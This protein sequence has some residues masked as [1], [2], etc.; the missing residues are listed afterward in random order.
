MLSITPS[1][2]SNRHVH[3]TDRME[4]AKLRPTRNPERIAGSGSKFLVQFTRSLEQGSVMGYVLATGPRFFLLALVDENIRF[5]GFQCLRL[6]DVKN[7]QV[8][9]RHAT[10]VEAALKLRGQKRPPTPR[11]SVQSIQELLETAGRLFPIVTIH[12]EKVARDVCHIGRVL[13][14]SESEVSLL[15]IGPDACWDDEVLSYRTKQIT[16]VDFGG[17]YEQA[18][19][20]VAGFRARRQIT[21]KKV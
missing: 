1:W 8:P 2:G 12:R 10:F 13:S 6:Q 18:L 15:E 3:Y 9:A 11:I 16:R 21:K 5:N 4:N 19:T 14:A 17:E 20:L 7:L